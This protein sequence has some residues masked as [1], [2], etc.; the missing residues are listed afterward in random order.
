MEMISTVVQFNVEAWQMR[1]ERLRLNALVFV[2]FA[3]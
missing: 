3:K 2:N 1:E